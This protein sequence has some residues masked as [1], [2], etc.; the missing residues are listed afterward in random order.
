M[1]RRPPGP[2]LT[3]TLFPCPTLF[4]AMHAWVVSWGVDGGIGGD[5][6]EAVTAVRIEPGDTRDGLDAA[7]E[8]P[9]GDEY[10]QVDRLGDQPTRHGDHRFLHELLDAIEGG[11]RA[12]GVDRGDP[13]G[14][15]GVPGQIGR[16]HV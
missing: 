10:D 12:I 11:H 14:M 3:D 9:A 2:T 16:A 1:I 15:D 8:A 7:G 6:D 13:A 4:R 5:V